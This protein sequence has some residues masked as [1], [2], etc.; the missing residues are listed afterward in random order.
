VVVG[1]QDRRRQVRQ[2]LADRGVDVLRRGF[3]VAVGRKLDRDVRAAESAR[4]R[5]LVD[6]GLVSGLAPGRFAPTLIVGEST[7]GRSLTGSF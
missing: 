1:R 2:R 5:D 7:I 6:A 4:R 3:D